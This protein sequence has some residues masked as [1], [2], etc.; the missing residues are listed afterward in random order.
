MRFYC[1]NSLFLFFNRHILAAKEEMEVSQMQNVVDKSE[2]PMLSRVHEKLLS[3]K[4]SKPEDNESFLYQATEDISG[5]LERK[6]DFEC[7]ICLSK[8]DSIDEME[9]YTHLELFIALNVLEVEDIKTLS[10][11][12]YKFDTKKNFLDF[13]ENLKI[14]SKAIS[15]FKTLKEY[16][17]YILSLYMPY[18][19]QIETF[20]RKNFYLPENNLENVNLNF[21]RSL[22]RF[23]NLKNKDLKR[24]ASHLLE[25]WK[26]LCKKHVRPFDVAGR[27]KTYSTLVL[28]PNNFVVPG[29][30]FLEFYYWDSYWILRGLITSRL[31]VQAFEVVKNF[32]WLINYFGFVPNGT[33]K[34]YNRSQPPFF[35]LMLLELHKTGDKSARKLIVEEGIPAAIKEMQFWR[36][37]R[38]V[39]IKI[40]GHVFTLNRYCVETDYARPESFMKD[41][42]DFE[43]MQTDDKKVENKFY[44]DIKSAAESGWDFSTRWFSNNASLQSICTSDII[45][46]DLN[47]LLFASEKNLDFLIK[48]HN[49]LNQ[50]GIDFG[51]LS[52]KREEA[53]NSVLWNPF[54][55]SWNDY[56]FKK[57]TFTQD[58]FYFSNLFPLF[59]DIKPVDGNVYNILSKYCEILFYYKG[60]PASGYFKENTSG[61]KVYSGQQWDF[62]NIWAPHQQLMVEFLCKINEKSSLALKIAR[63]FYQHVKSLCGEEGIFYEKYS[64]LGD[65]A[66]GG[67]YENQFGFGWTNGVLLE[68]IEKFGDDLTLKEIDY[69]TICKIVES[70][71]EKPER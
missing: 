58:V 16:V 23:E 44:T 41:I 21:N 55:K 4:S 70:K 22:D 71:K 54:E 68:F 59:F 25:R 5:S 37:N 60:I 69:N 14:V 42:R 7:G 11:L 64:C 30:R 10:D 19:E 13:K 34:Y 17:L 24:V 45:P 51:D 31:M 63:D 2:N 39:E 8:S 67:E 49:F 28:L 65:K 18:K 62:P 66:G 48:E 9:K 38:K 57:N 52:M 50:S 35:V 27:E 40:N 43:K 6:K 3:D 32:I 46:V 15:S 36:E 12:V 61:E 33:R 1:F 20:Y 56:N 26:F 53:I 47:T 29:G